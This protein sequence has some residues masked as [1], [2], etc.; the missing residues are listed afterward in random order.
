MKADQSRVSQLIKQ[1]NKGGEGGPR[2]LPPASL[3]VILPRDQRDAPAEPQI[4]NAEPS[5]HDLC[6]RKERNAT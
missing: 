5:H 6:S 3:V 2:S 1:I 4:P